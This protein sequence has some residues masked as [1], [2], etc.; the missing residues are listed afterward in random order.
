M[1]DSTQ[2]DLGQLR[3]AADWASTFGQGDTNLA[4]RNRYA[5]NVDDYNAALQKAHEDALM[6][7]ISTGKNAFNFW[8]TAQELD[9]RAQ[10]HN[11]Q[12]A[13]A[14]P[15]KQAQTQAALAQV[16]AHQATALHQANSD[17]RQ[18]QQDLDSTNAKESFDSARH[19]AWQQFGP[20][21]DP[22]AMDMGK[23]H[24]AVMD[25][26]MATPAAPVAFKAAHVSDALKYFA[27]QPEAQDTAGFNQHMSELMQRGVTPQSDEWQAGLA[28]GMANFPKVAPAV[29]AKYGT[30]QMAS[31]DKVAHL[32]ASTEGIQARTAATTTNSNIAQQRETRLQNQ[33][34]RKLSDA[35]TT[36]E[37][38]GGFLSDAAQLHQQF[39]P[40]T[41]EYHDAMAKLIADYPSANQKKIDPFIKM[42]GIGDEDRQA[43]FQRAQSFRESVATRAAHQRDS[44]Q[45]GR[46]SLGANNLALRTRAEDFRESRQPGASNSDPSAKEIARIEK[47]APEW[48]GTTGI[49]ADKNGVERFGFPAGPRNKK[50]FEESPKAT[51]ELKAQYQHYQY[52]VA[53]RAAAEAGTPV[54]KYD[55]ESGKLIP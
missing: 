42:A 10:I 19:Q 17:A 12:M 18:A 29:V 2:P 23:Y 21:A 39:D 28:V 51:P 43:R 35:D 9:Q 13:A 41:A 34:D 36:K 46:E 37:D 5:G 14:A 47:D 53:K 52:L 44:A 49:M 8:K 3:H 30:T 26:D 24:Q 15:L 50:T 32:Q 1:A 54:K 55:P 27:A 11:A 25:A 48:M 20:G 40:G 38:T 31:P 45:A 7:E 16:Q 33:F 6:Q 22:S 4:Q